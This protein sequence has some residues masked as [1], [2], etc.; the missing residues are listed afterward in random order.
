V[1][2]AVTKNTKESASVFFAAGLAFLLVSL[3]EEP[4]SLSTLIGVLSGAVLLV[5]GLLFGIPRI[6][7]KSEGSERSKM[8]PTHSLR[9]QSVIIAVL[10]VSITVSTLLV[11]AYILNQIGN[12]YRIGVNLGLI[13]MI[14]SAAA[15]VYAALLQYVASD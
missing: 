14:I 8:K 9:T 11:I 6:K 2:N 12:H 15:M 4:L 13:S 3:Y 10:C 7:Q 5:V 1:S